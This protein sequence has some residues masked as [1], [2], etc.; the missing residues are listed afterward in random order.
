MLVLSRR[1]DESLLIAGNIRVTI[2]KSRGREVRLGIEAPS[3]IPILR[4]ELVRGKAL[5]EDC[6]PE[7]PLNDRPAPGA[8]CSP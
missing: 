8:K 3:E 2:L 1:Q 7:L 6:P 4:A 5:A